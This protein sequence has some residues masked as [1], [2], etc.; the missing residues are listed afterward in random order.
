M[1]NYE[2]EYLC[3]DM[4]DTL[5]RTRNYIEYNALFDTTNR[6]WILK[7]LGFTSPQEFFLYLQ[8]LD[9][10]IK[11]PKQIADYIYNTVVS[12]NIFMLEAL[13][14]RLFN[15][16]FMI[17]NE[18]LKHLKIVICTHR[19]FTEKGLEY[20]KKWLTKWNTN[21]INIADIHCIKSK[22]VPNKIEFLRDLYGPRNF[23][24]IDDN[25]LYIEDNVAPNKEP[26]I[27][28]YNEHN[29]FKGYDNQSKLGYRNGIYLIK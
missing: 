18:Q 25:P 8:S 26:E 19:G 24:L 9:S 22:E 12:K 4:D 21:K 15:S 1:F 7:E 28:L 23:R 20:T 11:A 3:L 6:P 16:L 29:K 27:L 10:T 14:T 13:P 2:F 5:V 17:P